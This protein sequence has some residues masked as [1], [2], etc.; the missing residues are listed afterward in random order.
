MKE[1]LGVIGSLPRFTQRKTINE[2][3]NRKIRR[4]MRAHSRRPQMAPA[5]IARNEATNR[6]NGENLT[7]IPNR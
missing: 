1:N 6:K 2:A 5:E 3:T 4:N 7:I